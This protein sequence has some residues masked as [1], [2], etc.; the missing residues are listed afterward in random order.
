MPAQPEQ[1]GAPQLVTATIDK[2]VRLRIRHQML[3]AGLRGG[4][5][6]WPVGDW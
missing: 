6:V 3:P 1:S 5:L 4:R 2:R